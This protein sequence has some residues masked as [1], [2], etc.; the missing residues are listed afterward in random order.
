MNSFRNSIT[1]FTRTE[2]VASLANEEEAFIASLDDAC[3]TQSQKQLKL[4]TNRLNK[5]VASGIKEEIVFLLAHPEPDLWDTAIAK[6]NA[7]VKESAQ[8]YEISEGVYD[9]QVGIS[10]AEDQKVYKK[11]RSNAWATLYEIVHDY[12]TEDNVVSIL[13]D[14]FENKFR[15][16]EHDSPR[17]WKNEEE[18]DS[19]FRIAKEYALN[20]LDPLSLA[21][22]SDHVEICLLYTSRCV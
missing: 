13:R 8:R 17:L 4:I 18:I 14:R 19:A 11:L 22:T 7:I 20:V 1:E 6:F 16:D 9:F 3:A 10:K 12:L 21:A 15:Y 2:L 5:N